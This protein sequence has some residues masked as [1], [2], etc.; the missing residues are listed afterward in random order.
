MR[1]IRTTLSAT[2]IDPAL[3]TAAERLRYEG[4]PSR[5][6]A[7]PAL[8]ALQAAQAPRQGGEEPAAP[9]EAAQ[10]GATSSEIVVTAQRRSERL[11]DVP[12]AISAIGPEALSGT[13]AASIADLQGTVPGLT[14]TGSA[15]LNSTNLVSTRGIAGQPVPIGANQATAI[16]LDDV[17]LSKP[18]AGFFGL[19]DVE[20]VEVLRGPQGT[21]YGRNATAG[22]INI[23]TRAPTREVEGKLDANYANFNAVS[24]GGFLGGPIVGDLAGSFSGTFSQ[25]EGFFRNTLTGNRIGDASSLSARAKLAYLGTGTFD[26]ILSVDHTRKRSEDIF[27]PSNVV[28]GRQQYAVRD[29]TTDIEDNVKTRLSTGGVALTM[30]LEVAP[31]LTVTSVTSCGVRTVGV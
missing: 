23:I 20:R 27:T 26:A 25:R 28:N 15:G 1:E 9:V 14:I 30:N 18:D 22:A 8:Q 5:A 7:Q 21:L 29:V 11:Q 16:Y 6:Q 19:R 13:G 3:L 12:I 17:Y 31:K 24:I 2:S 10:D 4:L